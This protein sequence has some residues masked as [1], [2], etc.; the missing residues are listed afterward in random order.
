MFTAQVSRQC[1]PPLFNPA[2]FDGDES[3]AADMTA[4]V[5]EWN[6]LLTLPRYAV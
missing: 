3:G 1:F 4:A 5:G 2:S 6:G